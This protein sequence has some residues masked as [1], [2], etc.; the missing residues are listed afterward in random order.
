MCIQRHLAVD[1]DP[2]VACS[3]D[4]YQHGRQQRH[5]SDNDLLQLLAGAQP[6][7]LRF[8]WVQAQL[9]GLHPVGDVSNAC[10]EAH[11]SSVGIVGWR[12]DVDFA[13]IGINVQKE[14]MTS[15]DVKQLLHSV[16]NLQQ[17]PRTLPC[18]TP[19]STSCI[20]ERSPP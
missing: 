17:W 16:Q 1:D 4:D 12:T 18:G 7:D 5:V 2:E 13:D 10:S 14:S 19:N 9:A 3:I 15:N 20:L 8:G 11:Y 6:Q